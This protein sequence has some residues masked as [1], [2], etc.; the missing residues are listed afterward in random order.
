M[1][2][3]N[4]SSYK[5][6][7][8]NERILFDALQE[9][10]IKLEDSNENP[11]SL[12]LYL[13]DYGIRDPEAK[14]KLIKATIEVILSAKDSMKLTLADFHSQFS[15]VI[16]GLS[17]V[18]EERQFIIYTVTWIG[19]NIFPSAYPVANNLDE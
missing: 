13:W 7:T 19:L 2:S 17:D 8:A 12:S 10:A 9:V 16:D 14:S 15:K 5:N 6:I 4:E 18:E 1:T 3:I 11:V